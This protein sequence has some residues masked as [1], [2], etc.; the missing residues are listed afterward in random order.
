MHMRILI[1]DR[2]AWDALGAIIKMRIEH[3]EKIWMAIPNLPRPME[4]TMGI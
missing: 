1:M 4:W 3:S 2:I